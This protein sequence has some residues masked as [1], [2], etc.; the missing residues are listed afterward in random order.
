MEKEKLGKGESELLA[1]TNIPGQFKYSVD[2]HGFLHMNTPETLVLGA[3]EEQ[4]EAAKVMQKRFRKNL[5]KKA[6]LMLP[7][8]GSAAGCPPPST[9]SNANAELC[10]LLVALSH[11]LFSYLIISCIF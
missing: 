3:P 1:T 11:S 4:H 10:G 2:H 8:F 7:I 5:V 6:G 9:F